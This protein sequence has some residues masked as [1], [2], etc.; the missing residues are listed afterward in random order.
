MGSR[1]ASGKGGP[2]EVVPVSDVRESLLGD[3]WGS[4]LQRLEELRTTGGVDLAF[5]CWILSGVPEAG[6][7]WPAIEDNG[8]SRDYRIAA[9][10]GFQLA[11]DDGFADVEAF[12]SEMHWMAGRALRVDGDSAP[13]VADAVSLLGL[14][15]G[16]KVVYE[17]ADDPDAVIPWM[18]E[19]V[20]A[21]DDLTLEP[22]E[23]VLLEAAAATVDVKLNV[24]PSTCPECTEAM[25]SK[26]LLPREP[27]LAR[28]AWGKALRPADPEARAALSAI[29]L[30]ALAYLLTSVAV[31]VAC[32]SIEDLL[33]VLERVPHALRRWTWEVKPS[34]RGAVARQWNIE[35]EYHVQNLLYALLYPLFPDLRDEENLPSVGQKK[36]RVDFEI[37][38]LDCLLEIKF[39]RPKVKPQ[40]IIGEIAEDTSL[41]RA[42][43]ARMSQ[44][45]AFIWDEGRNVQEHGLLQRGIE[46]LGGVYRAVVVS[47]PVWPA[48]GPVIDSI[49]EEPSEAALPSSDLAGE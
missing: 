12:K 38:S 20:A 49:V 37:P 30:S 35:N 32:P 34:V 16:A 19:V 22:W 8:A 17:G 45:V 6:L 11:S 23:K 27:A 40:E 15:L 24:E 46:E 13:F 31:D 21:A 39:M 43:R 42:G 33:T 7:A 10:R 28:S 2:N 44:I 14:A 29:R 26:G 36:P 1:R 9:I 41:Y 4:H 47:A 25:A 3:S 18:R 48:I 5:A